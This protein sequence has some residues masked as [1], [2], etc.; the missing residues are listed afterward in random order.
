MF[1]GY[2]QD[3]FLDQHQYD[4][5]FEP[6]VPLNIK[7]GRYS[8]RTISTREELKQVFQ[9]RHEVFYEELL[10]QDIKGIDSDDLDEDCD[11]L[12]ILDDTKEK[13]VANYRLLSTRF[14]DRFYSEN[15]FQISEFL[16]LSGHKLEMGRACVHKDYRSGPVMHLLWRGVAEYI[17][18]TNTEYLFGC[19]SLRSL[20]ALQ[21]AVVCEQLKRDGYLSDRFGIKLR[22]EVEVPG[23]VRNIEFVSRSWGVLL[24]DKMDDLINPLF[25][26]Y[27]KLGAKLYSKPAWDRKLES[28]D[29]LTVLKLDE[30]TPA[31][32]KRYGL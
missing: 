10:N 8:I 20:E 15:E 28:I 12:I 31:F 32:A 13:I 16:K 26:S 22:P 24:E 21:V 7:C 3:H 2:N 17:K 11:H 6:H 27:L 5:D 14:C 1:L 30:M 9:F 25:K 19:A 4:N 23:L 18:L 29:F